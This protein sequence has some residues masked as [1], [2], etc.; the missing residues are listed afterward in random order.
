L[1]AGCRGHEWPRTS[2]H[3]GGEARRGRRPA[4]AHAALPMPRSRPVCLCLMSAKRQVRPPRQPDDDEFVLATSVSPASRAMIAPS[5]SPSSSARAGPLATL[6]DERDSPP[7]CSALDVSQELP[8]APDSSPETALLR[9]P[10]LSCD[11][12]EPVFDSRRLHKRTQMIVMGSR[13]HFRRCRARAV[14]VC[15]RGGRLT[16]RWPRNSTAGWVR[17]DAGANCEERHASVSAEM[18]GCAPP[19]S[20][21]RRAATRRALSSRTRPALLPA[22][23]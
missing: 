14:T 4:G 1:E 17:V 3:A 9:A 22:P 18:S 19:T 11:L 21:A 13:R 7:F 16:S 10:A 8:Q 5:T 20:A 12:A 15:R 6:L 23:R 2:F